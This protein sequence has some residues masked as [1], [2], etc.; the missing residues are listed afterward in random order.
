V[1]ISGAVNLAGCTR[2]TAPAIEAYLAKIVK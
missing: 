2:C 1:L